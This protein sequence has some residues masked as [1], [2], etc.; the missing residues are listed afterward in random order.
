M[1][2]I[3]EIGLLFGSSVL[4][5]R[6]HDSFNCLVRWLLEAL[7]CKLLNVWK[8]LVPMYSSR[9]TLSFEILRLPFHEG[10]R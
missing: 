9:G 5:V 6:K 8:L 10:R 1:L 7:I 3:Y 4:L 2:L